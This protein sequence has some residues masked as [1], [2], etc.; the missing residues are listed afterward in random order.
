MHTPKIQTGV[1]FSKLKSG[2]EKCEIYPTDRRINQF[3]WTGSSYDLSELYYPE[4]TIN[5]YWRLKYIVMTMSPFS[6][7]ESNY[8]G[9][10]SDFNFISINTFHSYIDKSVHHVRDKIGNVLSNVYNLIFDGWTD[11]KC[12]MWECSHHSRRQIMETVQTKH[13]WNFVLCGM[14]VNALQKST[15]NFYTFI[16]T[17]KTNQ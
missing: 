7:F 13:S 17:S 11:G 16:Y 12:N 6:L 10:I 4:E 3:F 15:R 14:R 1:G 8:V 5:I 9:M 2:I